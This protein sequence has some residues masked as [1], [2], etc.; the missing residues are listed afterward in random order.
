MYREEANDFNEDD[1]NV[2]YQAQDYNGNN[3]SSAPFNNSG[4]AP[5][6]QPPKSLLDAAVQRPFA[7]K[8]DGSNPM[9]NQQ[10]YSSQAKHSRDLLGDALQDQHALD[11]ATLDPSVPSNLDDIV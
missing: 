7:R 2:D 8:S 1:N 6:S 3:N 4:R 5:M 11:I 9:Q 10:M